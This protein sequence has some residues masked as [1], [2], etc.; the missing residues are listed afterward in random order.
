MSDHATASSSQFL[1]RALASSC[2]ESIPMN[3]RTAL[4]SGASLLSAGCAPL[5]PRA[6]N[7]ESVNAVTDAEV[8]F[9]RTMVDRDHR[10]FLR[11]V[12]AEAVFLNGG[13]PLVGREAVGKHWERFYAGPTPPFS[14][15]PDLVV[16]LA[17][18]ALAQSVGPVANASGKIVARFY[19]TWRLEDDGRWRV[20]F[21]DGYD[22]CGSR[23]A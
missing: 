9:A 22:V 5:A 7:P 18:G 15:Q 19:S 16:V 3:R 17:S 11:F 1:N 13:K 12:S 2:L 21:D 14:W 8:A 20:V 10:A 6:S 4:L 23:A